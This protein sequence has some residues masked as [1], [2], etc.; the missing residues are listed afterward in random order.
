VPTPY[1]NRE[2]RANLARSIEAEAYPNQHEVI[3]ERLLAHDLELLATERERAAEA[4]MGGRMITEALARSV[5]R[6]DEPGAYQTVVGPD[7]RHGTGVDVP[8][9][10]AALAG[11]L[12]APQLAFVWSHFIDPSGR[13]PESEQRRAQS[14]AE[15]GGTD[16]FG[17]A[18]AYLTTKLSL[19][20]AQDLLEWPAYRAA[21]LAAVLVVR[22]PDASNSY[23][24]DGDVEVIDADLGGAFDGE[25]RS[26]EEK[27]D[28]TSMA[29]GWRDQAL[30]LPK[31]SKVRQSALSLA[32]EFDYSDE[33]GVAELVEAQ[34]EALRIT[35]ALRPR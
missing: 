27:A 31:G 12:G 30:R 29:Q 13:T 19:T 14:A 16:P 6:F 24:I 5:A 3:F 26:A 7:P 15:Q 11:R 4:R 1:T 22:H 33:P 2:R 9:W 25:P 17:R 34:A 10:I 21:V 23:T 28:A 32:D 18:P 35:L 20:E 8:V